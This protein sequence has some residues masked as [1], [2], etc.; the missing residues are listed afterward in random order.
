[1]ILAV[2]PSLEITAWPLFASAWLARR[3]LGLEPGGVA[4]EEIEVEVDGQLV[5]WPRLHAIR[6]LLPTARA[7]GVA[8]VEAVPLRRRVELLTLIL[9]ARADVDDTPFL[10]LAEQTIVAAVAPAPGD[11][12]S[13]ASRLCDGEQP[14]RPAHRDGISEAWSARVPIA[15]PRPARC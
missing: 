3:W 13:A 8:L 11:A 2:T 15:C 12:P 7:R 9:C 14:L 10:Q 1:M 6:T 5:R 4:F